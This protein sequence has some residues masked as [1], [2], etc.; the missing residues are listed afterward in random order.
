MANLRELFRKNMIIA[1]APVMPTNAAV[2]GPAAAGVAASTPPTMSALPATAQPP[3]PAA[4][5]SVA[6]PAA[7]TAAAG[8]AD[9]TPQAEPEEHSAGA[10]AAPAFSCRY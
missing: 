3:A 9:A 6:T 8:A 5:P 4:T 2:S 10:T 7:A 1:S